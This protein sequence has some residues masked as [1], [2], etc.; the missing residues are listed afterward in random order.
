MTDKVLVTN[1]ETGSAEIVTLGYELP[2]YD[3]TQMVGYKGADGRE[4][5]AM[6]I[7]I[8]MIVDMQ[9]DGAVT[10]EVEYV[11]DNSDS[12]REEAITSYYP[13]GDE[14]E[15]DGLDPASLSDV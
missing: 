13:V 10:T 1:D 14:P 9:D 3:V 4:T 11:L 2:Q 8:M 15:E 6:I 7:S 5:W 12:V